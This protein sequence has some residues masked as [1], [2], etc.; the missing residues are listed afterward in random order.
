M[1]HPDVAIAMA[2]ERE[3]DLLR[4]AGQSRLA[5]LA[6]CCRPSFLAARARSI[7]TRWEKEARAWPASCC[8]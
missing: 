3:R 2:H 8:A 4:A 5:R 6:R 7:S 1:I